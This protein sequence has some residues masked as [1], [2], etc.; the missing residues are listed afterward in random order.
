MVEYW[1]GLAFPFPG[2]FP[3]Q[4][5][6][7]C[8]LHYRQILYHLNHQGSLKGAL[9]SSYSLRNINSI[10]G[11]LPSWPQS[12]P[13]Y[14][15][16]ASPPNTVAPGMRVST[17]EFWNSINTQSITNIVGTL[18][19]DE[20][21]TQVSDLVCFQNSKR[22]LSSGTNRICDPAVIFILELT[23]WDGKL[24]Q[25]FPSNTCHTGMNNLWNSAITAF[26]FKFEIHSKATSVWEA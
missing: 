20:P 2:G 17:C 15:P 7:L 25:N 26:G 9:V 6:N 12:K 14:L 4:V 23:V 16:G 24:H 1:G 21:I 5:L 19:C 13:S 18:A 22:S 8:L 10:M 3:T 11:V